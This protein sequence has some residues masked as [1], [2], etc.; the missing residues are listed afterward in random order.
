MI[1][2]RAGDCLEGLRELP[3]ASA[4]LVLSDPPYRATDISFDSEANDYPA[5]YREIARIM[6]P[7]AWFF[8]WGLPEMYAEACAAAPL[9]R[10]FEYIWVKTSWPPR[11]PGVVRP[12]TAHE[13]CWALVRSDLRRVSELYFAPG[14]IRSDDGEPYHRRRKNNPESAFARAGKFYAPGYAHRRKMLPA[15]RDCTTI[16]VHKNKTHL[17]PRE[18]TPHP[19]QKPQAILQYIIRGYCPPGGLVVDP[20]AGSASALL[21]ARAEGRSAL[22]WER[23]PEWH[24]LARGRIDGAIDSFVKK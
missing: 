7:A 3:D 4:D 20:F 8:L 21:A 2:L 16:L 1:E 19:T 12:S 17:P 22:G 23:D 9:R 15:G 11:R 24:K 18:R 10:K 13:I 6:K 5:I 14:E